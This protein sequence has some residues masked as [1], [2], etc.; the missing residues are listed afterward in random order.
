MLRKLVFCF[1]AALLVFGLVSCSGGGSSSYAGN[2][3]CIKGS[4]TVDKGDKLEIN[5]DGSIYAYTPGQTG[6]NG[7]WK[8]KDGKLYLTFDFLGMTM[9]GTMDGDKLT[10]DDGGV[11]QKD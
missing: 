5:K 3:T 7:T 6:M 10:F 2:Y 8:V 9:R 1:I 11:L 4:D